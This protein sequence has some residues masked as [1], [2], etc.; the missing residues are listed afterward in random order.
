MAFAL[1]AELERAHSIA[2]GSLSDA[3][4]LQALDE[5]SRS[6]SADAARLLIE[7]VHQSTWSPLRCQLV[8]VLGR[9]ADDRTTEFLYR[10]ARNETDLAL[11]REAVHALGR[12]ENPFAVEML[13]FIALRSGLSMRREA[14]QA[15]GQ[16]K[17]L[18]T[19]RCLLD[20]SQRFRENSEDPRL[21]QSFLLTL[22]KQGIT[23]IED[24]LLE[25]MVEASQNASQSEL[26]NSC[27]L[28]AGS[29]SGQ[30]VIDCLKSL[31]LDQQH[32]S[33]E[34]RQAMLLRL[35][36]QKPEEARGSKK[37]TPLAQKGSLAS[38][39]DELHARNATDQKRFVEGISSSQL[40]QL[41]CSAAAPA[42][43]LRLLDI[44]EIPSTQSANPSG[45][46]QSPASAWRELSAN[47]AVGLINALVSQCF[48]CTEKKLVERSLKALIGVSADSG[49]SLE[50]RGR[51]IRALG[52]IAH[53][54]HNNQ[55]V[56][57]H[58]GK[59]HNEERQLRP[60]L[61]HALGNIAS[62]DALYA[63][64]DHLRTAAADKNTF[65]TEGEMILTALC[66]LPPALLATVSLRLP[67]VSLSKDTS[68]RALLKLMGLGAEVLGVSVDVLGDALN[69][70]EF[71]ENLLGI[72]A[73]QHSNDKSHWRMLLRLCQSSSEALRSRAL[74]AIF[75]S[76]SG[77]I[78]DSAVPLLAAR[79][80]WPEALL[81]HCFDIFEIREEEL[82]L[83]LANF[84]IAGASSRNPQGI[85]QS[86]RV[87]E[88]AT[89]VGEMIS[90]LGSN[91]VSQL[92]QA[93][94][95]QQSSGVDP[96]LVRD[97]PEFHCFGEGLKSVL[98]NSEITFAHPDIFNGGVDKSTAI[99][100]LVKSIDLFLQ[101]RIGEALFLGSRQVVLDRLR[102]RIMTLGLQG[103]NLSNAQ[104]LRILGAEKVFTPE[105]FPS[106]K[107]TKLIQ[108]VLG[109]R[110]VTEQV[111]ILDGLK[112][113]AVF[114]LL[115]VHQHTVEGR[116]LGP[117]LSSQ[118]TP[119][120]G[121]S[122]RSIPQLAWEMIL[123]QEKR[124]IAAHR[125]TVLD[126]QEVSE[127]RVQA[128]GVI[129]ALEQHFPPRQGG[130]EPSGSQ[131]ASP[132]E[133]RPKGG[134]RSA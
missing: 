71:S 25:L 110:F 123:L 94:G 29:L 95:S 83:D 61:F 134:K 98:R 28:A 46:H 26:L 2:S 126:I 27:L 7:M 34:L 114:L 9:F 86:K 48:V 1:D 11:A 125:G 70:R 109:G 85:F 43:H 116:K 58:L 111:K 104:I 120:Q 12:S 89:T 31:P 63:L 51:A 102:D 49:H 13:T 76:R 72:E 42:L 113:W 97:L 115:F 108:S 35:E 84:L 21:L 90:A 88:E 118:S 3:Q 117:V 75:R 8:S 33:C 79:S 56:M 41:G 68:R 53:F 93:R 22:A 128:L 39:H 4:R 101:E 122:S 50:L 124:N 66:Q 80:D 92:S 44:M 60:S 130:A 74:E 129:A 40:A 32:F 131:K 30:K 20:N 54:T 121:A 24:D 59:I 69:S 6:Q 52:Q 65:E 132:V 14:L 62:E 5:I 57:K 64:L 45:K 78:Q 99:I 105:L 23:E 18:T 100:E 112:G 15:L 37:Q 17:T 73:C 81:L 133:N 106:I 77:E 19:W 47:E 10:A 96:F 119:T 16:V 38:F 87:R 36:T 127:L 67:G 82:P 91:R 103:G 107:L 55:K